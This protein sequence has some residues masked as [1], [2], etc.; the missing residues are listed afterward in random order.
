MVLYF[1]MFTLMLDAI[2]CGVKLLIA[3]LRY[4]MGYLQKQETEEVAIFP[5]KAPHKRYS[6]WRPSHSSHVRLRPI[7]PDVEC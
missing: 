5:P 4:L 1:I 3:L 2:L 6:S 7:P